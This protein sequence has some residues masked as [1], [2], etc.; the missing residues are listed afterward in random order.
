MENIFIK[1]VLG[2]FKRRLF[3]YLL[4]PKGIR[5]KNNECRTSKINSVFYYITRLVR[6]VAE[7]KWGISNFCLTSPTWW[8][9]QESNQGHID[10]QSIALPTELRYQRNRGANLK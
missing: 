7:I 1:A 9:L 10:F 4:F 2:K 8:Y 5:Y 6:D 3:Q